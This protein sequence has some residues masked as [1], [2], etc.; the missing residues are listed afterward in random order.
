M[1][2]Y[3][4]N[5]YGAGTIVHDLFNKVINIILYHNSQQLK[6]AIVDC[7]KYTCNNACKSSN[8]PL[9]Y[10]FMETSPCSNQRDILYY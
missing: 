8:L 4:E 3:D 5:I 1:L 2:C 7:I 9:K 6:N 10:Y